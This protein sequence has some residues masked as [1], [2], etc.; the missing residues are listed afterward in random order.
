MIKKSN[1]ANKE[2]LAKKSN[3][4]KISANVIP[5]KTVAIDQL[6]NRIFILDLRNLIIKKK[7]SCYFLFLKT[8]IYHI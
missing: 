3:N 4:S 7:I 2:Y 1:S 8:K 6:N 5:E